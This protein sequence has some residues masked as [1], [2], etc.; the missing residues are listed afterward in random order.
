LSTLSIHCGYCEVN[1]VMQQV[2][3][4]KIWVASL[5]SEDRAV[6]AEQLNTLSFQLSKMLRSTPK[7]EQLLL[8]YRATFGSSEFFDETVLDDILRLRHLNDRLSQESE[9]V[10]ILFSVAVTS[11]LVTCSRLKRAGDVRFKTPK[12]MLNI[13]PL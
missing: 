8:T 9:L 10:G 2:V 11:Q 3:K 5:A 13:P 12:E 7:D 6:V 4:A 1:P